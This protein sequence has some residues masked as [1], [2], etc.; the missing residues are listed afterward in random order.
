MQI[1]SMVTPSSAST[2]VFL[3]VVA[4]VAVMAVWGTHVAGRYLEEPPERARRWSLGTAVAVVTWM[5]VTGAVSGS[6]VLEA[7]GTP[8]PGMFF[9][10]GCNG[11][12]L[13]S[14]SPEPAVGWRTA[15]RWPRWWA[16]TPS[17]SRSSWS[18]TAGMARARC[19]CR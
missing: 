8:P 15:C 6:G 18:C 11:L 1:P 14:R 13:S 12:A 17:G 16:S 5:A 10:A 2:A 9:L 7:P 19:P 3:V 4:A